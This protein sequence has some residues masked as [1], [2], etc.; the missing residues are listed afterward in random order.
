MESSL[1]KFLILAAAAFCWAA[2]STAAIQVAVPQDVLT[3]Y[4]RLLA[5]RNIDEIR[6]YSGP[7]SRRD[8]VEVI[9][10]QQALR[11]GGVSDAVE[12]VTVDSY[13][14]SLIEVEQGRL[15]ATATSV[16][17]ADVKASA[18]RVSEPLIREGEYVVGFYTLA[19]NAAVE[20]ATLAEL[21]QMRAITNK[22][23][24]NDVATMESLGIRHIENA[25]TFALIARMLQSGRADFT[26]VS[27][28]PSADMGFE[29]EGVRLVPVQGIKVAMP[30]SRHFLVAPG[31]EGD[32]VL[33]AL[34]K[35]LNQMRREGRI[36]R[37]YS[38]GGFFNRKVDGWLLLNPSLYRQ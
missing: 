21:R 14:R 12:F 4:Q 15:A 32:R 30:G 25:P 7:G 17:A 13:A 19:G 35:G 1:A 10:F 36:R 34:A 20:N 16:W 38:D 22:A 33:H 11:L 8:T 24:K 6:D 26:M 23:W 2:V 3:D 18:A 37:A 27:F 31:A 28:K 9:L 5:G 29:V